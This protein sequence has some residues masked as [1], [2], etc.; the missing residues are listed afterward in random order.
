[1]DCLFSMLYIVRAAT[2]ELERRT[3]F[4]IVRAAEGYHEIWTVSSNRASS[5]ARMGWRI[6]DVSCRQRFDPLAAGA[7]RTLFPLSFPDR[8]TN[9]LVEHRETGIPNKKRS[10]EEVKR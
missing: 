10:L 1:M 4:R 6:P 8:P 5:A 7:C 3:T 2:D 9:G